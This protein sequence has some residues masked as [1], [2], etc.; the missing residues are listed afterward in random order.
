MKEREKLRLRNGVKDCFED[1]FPAAH[2]GEPVVNDGDAAAHSSFIL[3]A[4]A[5]RS[6]SA[7]SSQRKSFS[8]YSSRGTSDRHFTQWCFSVF[9]LSWRGGASGCIALF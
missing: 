4:S 6:S 8:R 7:H 3:A 1:R 5:C 9:S 2:A